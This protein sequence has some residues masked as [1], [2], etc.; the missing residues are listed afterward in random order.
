VI[1]KH[2]NP[3]GVAVG[4]DALDAYGKAFA[5]DPM[6]AFGGIVCLNR[7]VDAE[8][9]AALKEQF[10][11]VLFA[12][13]YSEEA[14]ATLA[15]KENMRI[16]DD[17]DEHRGPGGSEPHLRQVV[18]GLLVQDRDS[19]IERRA[20]LSVASAREPTESE[21]RDLEFAWIV[22]KHVK[23]NA[24]V[25]CRDGATIGI[26]AGQM[27]RVDSVRVAIEKARDGVTGGALASDA[28]FPFS[29]GPELAL[30]AGVT[31]IVQPGGSV[32]DNLTI[33]AVDNAGAAM[34]F[35]GRR[36]FRH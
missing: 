33:E 19:G 17:Q 26:G 23:S 1:I 14:L 3:C 22:C 35:T 30:G 6:S 28:Y 8:L 34:V 15:E 10:I 9:A 5:C 24:I 25:I 2:N 7:D 20:D 21:W 32:R 11:E 29:D 13:G 18:G 4:S 36:H 27:S 16:L 12:R 31:S